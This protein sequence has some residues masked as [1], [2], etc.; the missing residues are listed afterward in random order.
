MQLWD[1]CILKG[2]KGALCNFFLFWSTFRFSDDQHSFNSQQSA[3]SGWRETRREKRRESVP[4]S[5]MN[6]SIKTMVAKKFLNRT[7]PPCSPYWKDTAI[8][9]PMSA[10]SVRKKKKRQETSRMILILMNLRDNRGV[11]NALLLS[12]RNGS[13]TQPVESMFRQKS[14]GFV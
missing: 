11:H 1:C 6:I 4:Y 12:A 3:E 5:F 8:I 9:L 2:S 7:F 10:R 13:N 14:L